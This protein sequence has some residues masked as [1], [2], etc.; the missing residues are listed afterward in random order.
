M[1]SKGFF[2]TLFGWE[3]P[4]DSAASAPARR[5][6]AAQ[7]QVA[8]YAPQ[9]Q[10]RSAILAR[11]EANRPRGE[12]FA[13]PSPSAPQ[14][15]APQQAAAQPAVI[16]AA[17]GPLVPMPPRRPN[18]TVMAALAPAPAPVLGPLPPARPTGIDRVAVASIAPATAPLPPA[19]EA[20]SPGAEVASLFGG[21]PGG[22]VLGTPGL[23]A[24]ITEGA[25]PVA[26]GLMSYAPHPPAGRAIPQ[27]RTAPVAAQPVGLRAARNRAPAPLTPARLDRS[28]FL[29]LTSPESMRDRCARERAGRDHRRPA[30]CWPQGS[31]RPLVRRASCQHRRERAYAQGSDPHDVPRVCHGELTAMVVSPQAAPAMR[32]LP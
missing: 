17:P 3:E 30:P 29:A 18:E 5:A 13:G 11:A 6:P 24:V 10:P 2:A 21:A 14:A 1:Q 20:R 31:P 16:A 22:K 23:P 25:A 27:A 28:N 12:T 26:A 8:A 19:R 4:D 32:R 7:T 9:E 15:P